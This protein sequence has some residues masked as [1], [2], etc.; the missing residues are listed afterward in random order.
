MA[1]PL[2]RG[3]R[4]AAALSIV[5][6]TPIAPGEAAAQDPGGV[7]TEP[8]RVF[9]DCNTFQCDS[10]YFRT[11]I[12]FVS[13]VRDRTSAQVHLIIT[14]TQTGGGGSVFTL[15]FI[16]REDLEGDD[17]E[18][19]HTTLG[20]DTDDEVVRALT[21]AIAAGLARYSAAI[22]RPTA[23]EIRST[24]PPKM[25]GLPLTADVPRPSST[26][27]R[28]RGHERPELRAFRDEV[29]DRVGGATFI[30]VRSPQEFSGEK[31]APDHLPQEQPYVGGHIPGAR[32]IPWSKAANDDGTFRNVGEL[33]ELYGS[34]TGDG[35]AI[36]YC[37]IGERSSHTWFV[38]KEL[39]GHE[40]VRNYDGSWTEYGSLVG[41]PVE[42]SGG[43]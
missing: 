39:L 15:D 22:G 32:N 11:E 5:L 16:G 7:R 37:R 6:W 13:W 40:N 33:R 18:I 4:L 36:T 8:L 27:F 35:E 2:N 42:R 43:G 9:L 41:A 14:G 3:L 23:F 24:E 28:I 25:D 21:G 20:T 12:D 19:R 38:L 17:D 26:G 10:E 1:S 34:G 29:L 31:L 30:D